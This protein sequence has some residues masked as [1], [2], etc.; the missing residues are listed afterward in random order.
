[1]TLYPGDPYTLAESLAQTGA[2]V[3]RYQREGYIDPKV[4]ITAQ[5]DSEDERPSS[6]WT[7][8]RAPNYVLGR[9][10]FEG[11]RGVSANSLTWRMTV[12]QRRPS[13]RHWPIQ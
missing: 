7:S 4:S 5:R 13:A 8:T 10:T 9:L 11:N 2:I 1:M 3:K 6:S 12:W